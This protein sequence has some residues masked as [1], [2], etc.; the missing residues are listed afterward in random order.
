MT[1]MCDLIR[2]TIGFDKYPDGYSLEIEAEFTH[3]VIPIQNGWTVK[4]DGSLRGFG[5]EYISNKPL[6][7]EKLYTSVRKLLAHDDFVKYYDPSHRTSTHVHCNV[8][9]WSQDKL[10]KVLLT[11]YLCEPLLTR[12]GGNQREGNLFCL[13]LCDAE[14]NLDAVKMVIDENWHKLHRTF[15]LYKY[16]ALNIASIARLGTIEFRQMRGTNDPELIIKWIQ[17]IDGVI[18]F[19]E[20]FDNIES[21]LET[22]IND[23]VAFINKATDNTY[24]VA[25]VHDIDQNYSLCFEILDYILTKPERMVK[26]N[27]RKPT[28]KE[29]KFNPDNDLLD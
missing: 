23:P 11:Y 7:G 9:S 4:R 27:G 24:P 5:Y 10:Y 2:P 22:Y 28:T 13:R 3:D 6:Q 19:A 25:Y 1:T 17:K 20:G 26:L 18:K 8:Q 14:R 21:I 29:Y 16:A 15:D 12:W